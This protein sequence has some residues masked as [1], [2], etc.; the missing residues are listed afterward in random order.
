MNISEII[1]KRYGKTIAECTDEQIYCALLGEVQRLAEA[2]RRPA[3]GKKLYY[4]SAEFLIGKLLSN[5]LINLGVYDDVKKQL[6]ENGRDI[7]KIE[8]IENEPSLGNGG[9]GRLAACF[10]DSIAA[11]GL[12]GD[13]VGLK[14][15][16]GLFKQIFKDNR[17]TAVP[18]R[19]LTDESWLIK[20]D[21]TYTVKFKKCSVT[22]RMYDINVTGYNNASNRLHLFDI[23]SI[24]ESVIEKGIDFDKERTEKNLTLFLYPDDSD[25]AGRMLRI[26][27]QYLMVSA[28]AQMLLDECEARGCRLYDL[29]DYAVIQINDTH[30]TMVIPEL[31]RLL[32]ERG[33]ET[34]DA[35]EAV[36]KTC[37]Y[38]NH[39]ILA[40]ALEKWPVSYLKQ[41][42]PQLM[43]IIEVL[44]D[45]VRRKYDDSG[46]YIID[47]DE[48]VHMAHIDIH[49]SMSVNGVA[50][51]HTDILKKE[52]LN[53]FYKIYPEK[54]NN[55]TNGITFRRWLLH[56]N[57]ELTEL[58]SSLIGDG[59]KSDAAELKKLL[60]FKK[61]GEVLNRLLEIKRL[62]KKQLKEHLLTTQG[63]DINESSVFD[64]QVKR[65]HEY[66]RQ[67]LNA[68]YIIH[69]YL[70]IKG[71][72]KPS[73]PITVVFGAKA[74]PAYVI[75]RDI[76]HLVLC[77]SEV[78]NGDPEVSPY[79]KVVMVENYNVSEAEKLIPACD[80]SEQISLASKEASGTGNMK[81]MLNGAVTLGTEDGANVEIHELVGDDNI[82]IFGDPSETVVERYKKGS[83]K[84]KE[85]YEEN[86]DIKEA[87]DFITSETLMEVGDKEMLE[88]LSKELIGKDWFMTFP[89][90]DEYVKA[91]EKAYKDYE[92]RIKWAEKMLVNIANAGYFS[93][94]RTIKEYNRDIWKLR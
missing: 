2:K 51:L 16:F 53:G 48:R 90:F 75:A 69:K 87:V 12:N 58:I 37:A 73:A 28:G 4:F 18:D 49:Y 50:S 38:T 32:V 14:Y 76:I 74:A 77:L 72:K 93:S 57:P 91:R 89:D 36:T 33:L 78:I 20:T 80:I 63:I 8:E 9:L 46:L 19:W 7:C 70:E 66:K 92:N 94:D 13:G 3:S 61:D 25:D 55:K 22:A 52:E 65:L 39:T 83:Y 17:Q 56:C 54:F 44:D 6:A 45:K 23:D 24:D 1:T 59:F 31:I 67:Q 15:H 29:A 30:P 27:Q 40:E 86:E 64:I 62:K 21:K 85:Y 81:F 5:N 60:G 43:P 84:A 34:D 10:L 82:Y 35:I 41:V 71:G 26:Y 88:R 11:L 42:V 68:L 79:L 47:K